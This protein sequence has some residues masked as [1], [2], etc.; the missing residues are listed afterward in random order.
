MTRLTTTYACYMH[1]YCKHV[2]SSDLR[3]LDETHYCIHACS[4]RHSRQ[5]YVLLVYEALSY[6]LLVYEALSYPMLVVGVT[7][8]KATCY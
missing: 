8:V 3:Q 5:S 2:C 7:L 1:A 6:L 4:R